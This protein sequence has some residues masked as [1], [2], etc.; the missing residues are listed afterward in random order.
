MRSKSNSVKGRQKLLKA[1]VTAHIKPQRK[2]VK[3]KKT[4]I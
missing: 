3:K 1:K 4:S 2:A